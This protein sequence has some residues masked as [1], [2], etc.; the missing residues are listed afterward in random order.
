M[1]EFR[2]ALLL[3]A[4]SP[5]ILTLLPLHRTALFDGFDASSVRAQRVLICGASGGLGEQMAYRYAELGAELVLVARREAQLGVV[6]AEARRRGAAGELV[7]G[8]LLLFVTFCQENAGQGGM[9][10]YTRVTR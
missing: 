9:A 10:R 8:C 3:L 5:L 2:W 1:K 4:L 7:F 6:A